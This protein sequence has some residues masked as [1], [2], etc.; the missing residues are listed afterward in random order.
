MVHFH[1]H[2]QALPIIAPN[3]YSS[4]KEYET[5]EVAR[6]KSREKGKDRGIV[7]K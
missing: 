5:Q 7:Q 4:H 1:F 6:V 2:G 3:F